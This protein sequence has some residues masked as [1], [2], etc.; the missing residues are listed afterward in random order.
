MAEGRHGRA[1]PDV[2]AGSGSGSGVATGICRPGHEPPQIPHPVPG[3]RAVSRDSASFPLPVHHKH[4]LD[5]QPAQL[6]GGGQPGGPR[7]NDEHIDPHVWQPVTGSG[8]LSGDR[9]RASS[10][11]TAAPQ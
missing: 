4:P 8:W 5:A 1:A 6:D 11:A 10:S 7:A 2:S 9:V 3:M